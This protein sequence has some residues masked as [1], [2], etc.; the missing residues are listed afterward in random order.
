M[1]MGEL[2]QWSLQYTRGKGLVLQQIYAI[3]AN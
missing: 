2:A 3:G 1:N